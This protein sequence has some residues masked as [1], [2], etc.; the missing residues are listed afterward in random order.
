MDICAGILHLL[1]SAILGELAL[2]FWWTW[3]LR[4][5]GPSATPKL[6]NNWLGASAALYGEKGFQIPLP[7]RNIEG[8]S[9]GNAD[10][11][12]RLY[13]LLAHSTWDKP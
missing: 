9:A 7:R 1:T 11:K 4:E 3:L 10:G 8:L 6:Q 13:F 12:A 5:D 2:K